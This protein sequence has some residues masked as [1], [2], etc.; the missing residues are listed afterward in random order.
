MVFAKGGPN[1]SEQFITPLFI[2]QVKLNI[3]K[4]KLQELVMIAFGLKKSCVLD[5]ESQNSMDR[6]LFEPI[7]KSLQDNQVF[8]NSAFIS[9]LSHWLS[10]CS[11]SEENKLLLRN[12]L[13]PKLSVL[14]L[15]MNRLYF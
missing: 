13:N 7:L 12:V 8:I 2:E 3:S 14:I 9:M 1:L 4:F 15:K 11:L 6:L 10:S 5:F